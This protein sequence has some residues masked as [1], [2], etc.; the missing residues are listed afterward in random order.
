MYT[1]FTYRY[2]YAKNRKDQ[3]SKEPP[4]CIYLH[5]W[6]GGK[7]AKVDLQTYVGAL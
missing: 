7:G 5:A 1:Y 4:Y 6:S 2:T 3:I